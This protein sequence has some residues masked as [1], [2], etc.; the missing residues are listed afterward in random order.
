VTFAVLRWP[1][2]NGASPANQSG[3]DSP[4]S[5]SSCDNGRQVAGVFGLCA[6]H[7]GLLSGASKH[8][9]PKL[10]GLLQHTTLCWRR[11]SACTEKSTKVAI[12]N[13]CE[14][15]GKGDYN[16]AE[17][18]VLNDIA[19]RTGSAVAGSSPT[20]SSSTEFEI[21]TTLPRIRSFGISSQQGGKYMGNL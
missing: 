10:D 7:T 11:S 3:Y 15:C 6:G 17:P 12:L 5:K 9:S 19:Q 14:T 20:R 16:L 4:I 13:L 2:G 8:H 21:S 1:P 18:P